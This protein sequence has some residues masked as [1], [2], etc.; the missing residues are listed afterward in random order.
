MTNTERTRLCERCL[1]EVP[2]GKGEFFE[3]RVEAVADPTPPVLESEELEDLR[4][5][6]AELIE[7][8]KNV[9]ALEANNQVYRRRVWSLCNACLEAWLEDPFGNNHN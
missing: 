6:Y 7:Q 2:E 9:S 3:V 5:Q 1:T 8:L 4:S